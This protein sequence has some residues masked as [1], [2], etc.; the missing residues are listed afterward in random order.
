MRLLLKTEKKLMTILNQILSTSFFAA[1]ASF[2]KGVSYR[3]ACFRRLLSLG[4]EVRAHFAIERSWN[5][6]TFGL[7]AIRRIEFV[8]SPFTAYPPVQA[9]L[10]LHGQLRFRTPLHD[11]AK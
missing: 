6:S 4:L 7:P 8:R 2:G 10:F 3:A 11:P 9:A 5:S 1:I